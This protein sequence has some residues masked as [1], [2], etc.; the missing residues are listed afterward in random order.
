MFC[1]FNSYLRVILLCY[2]HVLTAY[3]TIFSNISSYF[4]FDFV[5]KNQK[6]YVNIYDEISVGRFTRLCDHQ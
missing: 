5:K 4:F 1:L 3:L 6:M 2:T